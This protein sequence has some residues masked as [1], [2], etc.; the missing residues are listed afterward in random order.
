VNRNLVRLLV[1]LVVAVLVFEARR[2]V[3]GVHPHG[4]TEVQHVALVN[5]RPEPPRRPPEPEKQPKETETAVAEPQP[6]ISTEFFK[7]DDYAPADTPP[8]P[9]SGPG[10]LHDDM[11]GV[12]ALGKGGADS[13]GIIGKRGG[14]DITAL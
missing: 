13:Y 10:G 11:L 5:P 4:R 14:R 1:A 8:A 2:Y 12:D 7:F 3:L 6:N 9:G